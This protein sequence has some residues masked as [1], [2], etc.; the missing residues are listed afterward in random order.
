MPL[1]LARVH[2]GIQGGKVPPMRDFGEKFPH[3]LRMPGRGGEISQLV[4]IV[5][6]VVELI[7][8][9]G[10]MHELVA[11]AFDHDQGGDRSL[12]QILADHFIVPRA[13]REL[14]G[15]ALPVEPACRIPLIVHA[16]RRFSARRVA[17]S[18]SLI[19]I[20]PT[21]CEL[22]GGTIE[23]FA[24][25]FDG[26]S[27]TG[28]LA[29]GAG[30]DEVIGEYLAEGAIA[31]LVMIKRGRYKF[32]HSPVDPGQLYDLIDDPDELRNLAST[33]GHAE[34]VREFLAEVARR[35]DLPA[36]HAAVLA[37]QRQRHLVYNALRAGRYTSWDF[38]PCRDASRQYV[39]NDQK[40]GALE[41]T[42]RFPSFEVSSA[43][44]PRHHR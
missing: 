36:L 40:L 39:R 11:P 21:L 20:A 25:P 27:L 29:G 31:P 10:R 15:Q 7:R 6:Q 3:P 1:P 22:A 43:L 42:A 13:S 19:D 18:A 32:V 2:R 30:R 24:A 23:D 35:W 12:R 16:P 28:Q 26:N 38:Q 33:P 34:L 37:S 8:I 41:A 5:D 4:R 44:R 9:D 17:Q 14:P